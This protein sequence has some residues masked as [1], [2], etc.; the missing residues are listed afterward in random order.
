MLRRS[1]LVLGLTAGLLGLAISSD[2]K[3]AKSRD[4]QFT[5]TA[6]LKDL[7]PGQKYR[8]WV[9]V[10]KNSQEQSAQLVERR[11][12]GTSQET[13]EG[14]Y[15]NKMIYVEGIAQISEVDYSHTYQVTRKEVVAPLTDG[16]VLERF[17][18]ADAKV[19]SG[20][21]SLKLIE[22]KTLPTD[23]MSKARI[24]YDAIFNHM[25][26]DKTGTGWGQGDSE[27]ACDSGKGNCTDF[28]AIFTSLSRAHQIPSKFEIG[29]SIPTPRG[30]GE[31]PGY[32]CWAFFHAKDKGWVPV[33][34]S[35]ASKNPQM[36][37]YLF[38]NLTE[39]RVT[40]TVGRDI[41]LEPKQAAG[42]LNFFV[43][44]YAEVDGQPW[45]KDKIVQKFNY[46]DGK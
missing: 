27:W 44:P 22:G 20:G 39:D 33:D 28:H 40:M 45:P 23:E 6:K 37:D 31:I 42:P 26:Y 35:D 10:P 25:K 17:T 41:T 13:T 2:T 18:K 15:G 21:K 16:K 24:F 12:N 43:Y 30:Q 29:F 34:I 4:F 3:A 9:P 7:K 19:P 11:S 32:H 38:G 1:F 14:Q 8:L 46:R 5:V 36:K